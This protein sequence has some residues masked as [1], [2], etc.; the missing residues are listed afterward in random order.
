MAPVAVPVAPP[1]YTRAQF[2]VGVVPDDGTEAGPVP[3]DDVARTVKL[4]VVPLVSPVITR[5]DPDPV[6]VAPP[7]DAVTV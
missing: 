6:T 4:Y 5:G 3:C 2:P 1:G 7:G